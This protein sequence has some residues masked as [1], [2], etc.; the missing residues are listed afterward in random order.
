MI[1][2]LGIQPQ[3]AWNPLFHQA[4]R[5]ASNKGNTCNSK[6]VR[7]SWTR[8][9]QSSIRC[10]GSGLGTLSNEFSWLI[11]F[12]TLPRAR[13]QFLRQQVVPPQRT[14]V[15]LSTLTFEEFTKIPHWGLDHRRIQ[16]PQ[17]TA[18]KA[19]LWAVEI[20]RIPRR[21]RAHG[22]VVVNDQIM[23]R[24]IFLTHL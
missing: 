21:F 24:Q 14:W 3:L 8:N 7:N 4:A 13:V 10:F 16:R 18:E 1:S 23:S 11:L 12:G 2:M 9:E 22:R 17:S 5:L 19:N 6:Q 15:W 20:A